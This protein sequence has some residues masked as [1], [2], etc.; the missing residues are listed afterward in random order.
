MH[1]LIAGSQPALGHGT[2]IERI[3][4]AVGLGEH[5]QC[6]IVTTKM[7]QHGRLQVERANVE[8][9]VIE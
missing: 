4:L 1:G 2:H 3:R 9:V 6:L 7:S 5:L 8:S